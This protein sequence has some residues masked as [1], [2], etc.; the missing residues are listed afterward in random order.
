LERTQASF[1]A[2]VV[3]WSRAEEALP[4]SAQ[5]REAEAS[6]WMSAGELDRA[7]AC[8]E[9]ALRLEPLWA[10]V[11]VQKGLVL[12]RQH[13]REEALRCYRQALSIHDRWKGHSVDVAEEMFVRLPGDLEGM[14][15]GWVAR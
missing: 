7:D 11:W 12:E 8:F 14:L 9:E 6:F 2:A 3:G 5:V 4:F 15:R 10:T 1:D 13:R